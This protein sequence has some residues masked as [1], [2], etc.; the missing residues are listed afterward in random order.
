MLK[1]LLDNISTIKSDEQLLV[2]SDVNG[3]VGKSL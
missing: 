3:N 1:L 2:D